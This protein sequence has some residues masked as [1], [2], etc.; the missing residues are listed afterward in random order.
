MAPVILI[1]AIITNSE[2]DSK[3]VTLRLLPGSVDYYYPGFYNGTVIVLK[4]GQSFLTPLSA[5]E[6]DHTFTAYDKL[7]RKDARF[8]VFGIKLSKN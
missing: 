6:V 2:Q 4:S 5:E 7:T 8:G 3:S 1:P